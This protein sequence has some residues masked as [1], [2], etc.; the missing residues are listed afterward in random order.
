[1]AGSPG[2]PVPSPAPAVSV[3]QVDALLERARNIR[4]TLGSLGDAAPSG[5]VRAEQS[6]ESSETHSKPEVEV[7]E[8]VEAVEPEAAFEP[9]TGP[10]DKGEANPHVMLLEGLSPGSK[11]ED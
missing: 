3:A 10:V 2:V 4:A 8:A 5:A 7:V 6:H 11:L 1:L 9:G